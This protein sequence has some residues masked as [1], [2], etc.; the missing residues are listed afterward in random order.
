[1]RNLVRIKNERFEIESG[2]SV[3][4]CDQTEILVGRVESSS[5]PPP[6]STGARENSN[7]H[8]GAHKII[9]CASS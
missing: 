5:G 2:I 4:D 8:N 1:M 6:G 3:E 9:A 7:A